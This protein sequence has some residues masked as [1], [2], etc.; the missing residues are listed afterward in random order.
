V[1]CRNRTVTISGDD[2]YGPVTWSDADGSTGSL[3]GE[4]LVA[5]TEGLAPG[6]ANADGAFVKAAVEGSPGHPDFTVALEAH[7]IVEAMYV[8]VRSG[9]ST[10]HLDEVSA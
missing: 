8:S 2:W 4:E 10:V 9:G 3:A 7:R 1:F 5:R 6:S